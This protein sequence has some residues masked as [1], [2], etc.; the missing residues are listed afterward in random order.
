MNDRSDVIEIEGEI[1]ETLP[2]MMFR[3]L[4]SSG[5]EE[6]IGKTL[7]CTLAGKMRMYRI[8]VLVGDKVKVE[9]SKYD[10]TKGRVT[11]RV[12]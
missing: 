8:R 3:V 11:F 2:N 7:L 5:S 12:K 6:L 1:T 10:L 4:V 9:V